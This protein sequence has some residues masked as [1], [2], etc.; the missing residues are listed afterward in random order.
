VIGGHAGTTILPLLSHLKL[1]RPWGTDELK[2]LIQRI[3]FGSW[4]YS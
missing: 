4:M 1:D 3:Q 2:A